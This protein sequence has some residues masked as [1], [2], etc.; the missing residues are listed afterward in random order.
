MNI[1]LYGNVFGG[2]P[3]EESDDEG[4]PRRRPRIFRPRINFDRDDIDTKQRFRLTRA[5]V[6]ILEAEIGQYIQHETEENCALNV[7]QEIILSLR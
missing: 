7:R 2:D 6:D 3:E 1:G 5:H 4:P